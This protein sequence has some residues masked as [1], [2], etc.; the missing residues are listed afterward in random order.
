MDESK[1][2]KS[3]ATVADFM[4]PWRHGSAHPQKRR[5]GKV[6]RKQLHRHTHTSHLKSHHSVSIIALLGAEVKSTQPALSQ[7]TPCA[8]AFSVKLT[9]PCKG[10]PRLGETPCAHHQT[11]LHLNMWNLHKTLRTLSKSH[12]CDQKIVYF[13]CETPWAHHQIK[14]GFS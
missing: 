9:H 1:L 10:Q 3:C 11:W 12:Y 6:Q 14:H 8:H 13:K 4:Q 5:K 2:I 7:P